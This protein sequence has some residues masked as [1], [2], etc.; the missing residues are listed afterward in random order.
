MPELRPHLR[1]LAAAPAAIC[2]SPGCQ[3]PVSGAFGLCEPCERVYRCML[4]LC[5]RLLTRDLARVEHRTPGLIDAVRASVTD[6]LTT[7]DAPSEIHPLCPVSE[8]AWSA[9]MPMPADLQSLRDLL[10]ELER[11]IQT[12]EAM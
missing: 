6:T 5:D 9:L 7:L 1:L 2:P 4:V 11:A 12:L 3:L 8:A 10:A